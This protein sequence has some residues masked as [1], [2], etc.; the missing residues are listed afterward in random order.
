MSEYAP[1][2]APKDAPKMGGLNSSL[3]QSHWLEIYHE[4]RLVWHRNKW[5]WAVTK[6]KELQKKTDKDK[7]LSSGTTD[8]AIAKDRKWEVA[9]KIYTSFDEQLGSIDPQL[10]K[11]EE[12]RKRAVRLFAKN[13]ISEKVLWSK[14]PPISQ[15]GYPDPDDIIR[16][17]HSFGIT[18]TSDMI[19]LLSE[20]AVHLLKSLPKSAQRTE[21]DQERER[22]Y[23]RHEFDTL[24]Q[25]KKLDEALRLLQE[26]PDGPKAEIYY[27]AVQQM[28]LELAKGTQPFNKLDY[29]LADELSGFNASAEYSLRKLHNKYI[30]EN[31][32][33]RL[34]T[35]Q[36]AS[37]AISRFIDVVGDVDAT[38]IT[39]KDA[40]RFAEK[41]EQDLC[42]A[43]KSIKAAVSYVSGMFD[44]C[45]R[46][47]QL[48][49][50]TTNPFKGLEL[51]KYG[52]ESNSYIPF[53]STQLDE[54]FHLAYLGGK[55]K[56]NIREHLLFSFL[57]TTGCRL[58]EAALLCWDNV[59]QHEEGWKY[60]D[61]TKAIV[62][63]HGSKRLLPI[64]DCLQSILPPVGQQAT[65]KGLVQSCDGRLFDYSIDADGKASRAASQALGRQISKIKADKYQVTH[66]LRGNLKDMLRDV[67][68][69][70]EI[71]DY[72][73]GHSQGDV[74]SQY[75]AGPNIKQ[76]YD[77]LNMVKHPYIRAYEA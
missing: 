27:S 24:K 59:V 6:P 7:K 18:V 3:W 76:R 60:V 77:A 66:S 54:L 45:I 57:I 42:L 19:N 13:G 26:N 30:V 72:I 71:N 58:D 21:E 36:S 61:L 16:T 2:Y 39:A 33:G 48:T 34:K 53:T 68:V 51:S 10:G 65:T 47:P 74:A 73:T 37:K 14:F 50:Y 38:L 1:K 41:L 31:K 25:L 9:A 75:G 35:K 15:F 20:E 11:D 32:W 8:E 40:Y 44:W 4:P 69:S 62:K 29:A 12:F 55:G 5:H 64:P 67:G 17:A 28:S 56:M 63:N 22:I 46:Q 43:N 70:K 23:G 49:A 52:K